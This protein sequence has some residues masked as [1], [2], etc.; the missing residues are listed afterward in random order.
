[1]E[2]TLQKFYMLMKKSVNFKT[3]M[4][5]GLVV[6][7]LTPSVKVYA[8]DTETLMN[9]YGLTLGKPDKS[10]LEEQISLLEDSLQSM[11]IQQE[12]NTEYNSVLEQ[13]MERVKEKT[14]LI[15]NDV[16]IYQDKNKDLSDKIQSEIL[17]ADID[18]L[19]QYDKVYKT[20]TG[21]ADDLLSSLN[22]YDY[23]YS[24][25]SLSVDVDSIEKELEEAKTLYVDSIDTYDLGD[26][27]NLK[28]I[29]SN[30]MYRTSPYG[31]RL[32]PL[33]KEVVRF[34][35][36]TDYRAV[37]GT[38]IYALFNGVVTGCGWSDSAGY[39]VTVQCGENIRYFVCHLSEILVKE[40]DKVNQYDLIGLS[41]NT[42]YRTTGPHLHIA[43]YINGD[44]VDIHPLFKNLEE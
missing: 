39:F 18:T 8:D 41:G 10:G 22:N 7:L 4:C 38:E 21:Y 24:Y 6:C 37:I 20:N 44:S 26:V 36:G 16:E 35:S 42:G 43:L 14:D 23:D 34:H 27:T 3:F 15:L 12:M 30:D 17:S 11:Q 29:M 9:I 40:G 13:F 5:L 1:M 32:D 19:L 2:K 31:Y 25:R 33:N 28:W